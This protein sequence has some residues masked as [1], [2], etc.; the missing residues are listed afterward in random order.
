MRRYR[1]DATGQERP[2]WASK[3]KLVDLGRQEGRD[4]A[5][6]GRQPIT[7]SNPTHDQAAVRAFVEAGGELSP[8]LKARFP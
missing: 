2:I 3:A 4:A 8:E 1:L 7:M 5:R 6:E